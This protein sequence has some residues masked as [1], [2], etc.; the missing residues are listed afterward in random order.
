MNE[1]K[2]SMQD[3]DEKFSKKRFW[4]NKTNPGN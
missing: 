1:V 2:K 3:V 4:E